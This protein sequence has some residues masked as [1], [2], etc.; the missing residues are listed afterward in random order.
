M[1]RLYREDDW[2]EMP[3]GPGGSLLVRGRAIPA[4]TF[5]N[6]DDVTTPRGAELGRRL[7]DCLQALWLARAR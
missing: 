4:V 6:E 5:E 1:E 3:R 2:E 7:Q